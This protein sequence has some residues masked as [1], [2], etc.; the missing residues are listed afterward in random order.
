LEKEHY[1]QW[2]S[3]VLLRNGV[4]DTS[5]CMHHQWKKVFQ[6]TR[7][8]LCWNTT[9]TRSCITRLDRL[10]LPPVKKSIQHSTRKLTSMCFVFRYITLAFNYTCCQ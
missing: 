8:P 4:D 1:F 10:T 6:Q 9:R 5:C 2:Y 3:V 7:C